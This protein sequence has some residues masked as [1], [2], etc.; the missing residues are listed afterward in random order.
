MDPYRSGE[1]GADNTEGKEWRGKHWSKVFAM[2]IERKNAV[3]V[4]MS[5][6]NGFIVI[7]I[8]YVD[9][10]SCLGAKSVKIFCFQ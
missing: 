10:I 7:N 1:A 6:L 3:T 8:H 9:A 4:L 2:T 5:F